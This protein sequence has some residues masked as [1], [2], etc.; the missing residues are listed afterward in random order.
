MTPVMGLD[1]SKGESNV[2]AL[3]DKGKPYRNCF[4]VSY[5]VEGLGLK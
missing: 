4:K 5:T 3:L 2:Q 1:I